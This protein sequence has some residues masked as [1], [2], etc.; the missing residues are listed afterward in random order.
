V[1]SLVP[2][3]VVGAVA[4]IG[5]LESGVHATLAGVAIGF[6]TPVRPFYDPAQFGARARSLVSEVEQAFEGGLTKEEAERNEIKLHDLARL[7]SETESPLERLERRLGMWVAMGVVPIFALANA[8]VRISG[9]SLGDP[10]GD[11]VLLGVALGLLLGKTIGV[12][13]ATW[14]TVRSGIARL[15]LGTTWHH[16]AGLAVTAG[17]GFTVALFV[18]GLSFDDPQLNDSAKIGILT[19]SLVAGILGFLLL[20]SAPMPPTEQPEER[21]YAGVS[22]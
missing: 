4:W 9:D 15:P 12:F 11:R 22:V 21:D 3:A 14:L 7:A 1:R 6:L 2:Y 16:V 10:A 18:A 13:G 20:R 8:G 19:G 17:I 5:L